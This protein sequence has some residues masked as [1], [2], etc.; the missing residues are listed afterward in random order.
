VHAAEH[1]AEDTAV[2]IEEDTEVHAT[3][4]AAENIEVH[5]AVHVLNKSIVITL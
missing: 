4:H 3:V 2:Q 1:A 5:A